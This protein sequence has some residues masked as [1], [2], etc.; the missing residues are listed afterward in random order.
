MF[1][2]L[3]PYEAVL[4]VLGIILFAV[5]SLA[6]VMCVFQKRG[7]TTLLASYILPVVM[8]GFPAIQKVSYERG[9]IELDRALE[10][11]DR[12]PADR[13]ARAHLRSKVEQIAPRAATDPK[14][15][16]AAQRAYQKLGPPGT[17]GDGEPPA[18]GRRV[19][20]P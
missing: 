10:R 17:A 5:L 1:R 15:R 2:G 6:L 11:V 13:A 8:I 18:R 4:M 12:H 19:G 16:L 7:V 14:A 3:Y 20:A 9:K